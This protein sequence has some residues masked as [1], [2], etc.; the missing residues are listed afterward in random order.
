MTFS[1]L[2]ALTAWHLHLHGSSGFRDVQA[3]DMLRYRPSLEFSPTS[4]PPQITP[5]VPYKPQDHP[6][7]QQPSNY[8]RKD[9]AVAQSNLSVSELQSRLRSLLDFARWANNRERASVTLGSFLRQVQEQR[10]ELETKME[11]QTSTA[12]MSFLE[13]LL[14]LVPNTPDQPCA[15]RDDFYESPDPFLDVKGARK[16]K[17]PESLQVTRRHERPSSTTSV[18]TPFLTTSQQLAVGTNE[19]TIGRD[20]K[21]AKTWSEQEIIG[22]LNEPTQ[23]HPLTA[24]RVSHVSTGTKRISLQIQISAFINSSGAISFDHAKGLQKEMQA[25]IETLALTVKEGECYSAEILLHPILTNSTFLQ[26]DQKKNIF[27]KAQDGSSEDW[28]TQ[29]VDYEM[30]GLSADA[31]KVNLPASMHT[32]SAMTG[33]HHITTLH[34]GCVS[35]DYFKAAANAPVAANRE[36][37]MQAY[38]QN[39]GPNNTNKTPLKVVVD[40]ISN[41]RAD[42]C[43]IPIKGKGPQLM[44]RK[45]RTSVEPGTDHFLSLLE[46]IRKK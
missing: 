19:N 37:E 18:D 40:K 25:G 23:Q 45:K 10:A 28:Q 8:D 5:L 46:L 27:S 17:A 21:T 36:F 13:C 9:Y 39:V 11:D 29:T 2:P 14:H 20:Q 15:T 43:N 30:M 32:S 3:S 16:D 34:E 44:A 22:L 4:I 26:T 7:A 24:Y 1:N 33:S 12:V 6:I 35:Y 31:V 42:V 41:T 38:E